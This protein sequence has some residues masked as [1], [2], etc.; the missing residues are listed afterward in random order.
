[1]ANAG[2][3]C[4]SCG[5][6]Y[7]PEVLFCPLDGTPLSSSRTLTASPN[8]IDPY[9]F[10]ELPGQ[11]Q[12]NALVGIGSMGRV[13]RAFQSGVE[14]DV[15]VKI[16]HR[17]LTGN[18][19]LVAR[20]H[21]E[22]KIASRL[23]HPNVVQVLMTGTLPPAID[24]RTGGEV[25]LVMEY[26]D[27]I[28]LLSALAAQGEGGALPLARTLHIILQLCEAVG[29]AHVNNIIHRDLKPENIM[30]VRRGED[31]DFVKVLDFGIARLDSAIE[32]S[33][34]QAG[35][36]FGT[37]KYISPE[38]AEGK[39]VG[40]QADCYAIATIL[41]QCLAGKTPFQG[42][43]P[44]ALLVQQIHG[45][46]ADLRTIPRAAYVPEPIARVVMGNLSK[47][48]EDRSE[49]ARAFGRELSL[50][51]RDAGLHL[52]TMHGGAPRGD[53]RLSSKQ[54]TRQ[55]EFSAE[56]KAKIA[57]IGSQ[58]GAG[59]N[60]AAHADLSGLEGR[61]RPITTYEEGPG[62]GRLPAPPAP[63][64]PSSE[65]PDD[66]AGE[67]ES[68][69]VRP[70]RAGSGRPLGGSPRPGHTEIGARPARQ[71]APSPTQV[72]EAAH[73]PGH[74]Q[75]SPED[76]T[77]TGSLE[78]QTSTSPAALRVQRL[79]EQGILESPGPTI[80]GSP[81]G[82]NDLPRAVATPAG[83]VEETHVEGPI[84]SGGV[85][86]SASTSSGAKAEP[87]R[88]VPAPHPS[89]PR[90]S[91]PG[92]MTN[93]AS[94][95]MANGASRSVH[96]GAEEAPRAAEVPAAPA[97]A[98]SGGKPGKRPPPLPGDT[99]T[100]AKVTEPT[101][102]EPVVKK[103]KYTSLGDPIDGDIPP[104]RPVTWRTFAL[105]ASLLVIVPAGAL[106]VSHAFGKRGADARSFDATLEAAQEA[107]DKRAWDAPP[108]NNVKELTDKLLAESPGDHRVLSLRSKAAEGVLVDGMRARS[109]GAGTT[110]AL[111]LFRLAL[112]LDPSLDTAR[113]FV[114]E[115][116]QQQ[117]GA[118]S[119][120]ASS[121]P[122]GT[123]RPA[124]SSTS[125]AQT[126]AQPGT[127]ASASGA[128]SAAPSGSA[129]GKARPGTPQTVAPQKEDGGL[130][131]PIPTLEPPPPPPPPAGS[132][133]DGPF[134]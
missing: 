6:Q 41:Y 128:P 36:I 7:G 129:K 116:E 107:L 57:S 84:S 47:D 61:K 77:I 13:Y 54:R 91:S 88:V 134:I 68:Q 26:L 44:M 117:A 34:T 124:T 95:S 64:P 15:A 49:N 114:R 133:K 85:R 58:N 119:S 71:Q 66:D 108:G 86:A 53:L 69:S 5:G 9:L 12:L 60:G 80:P 16:L 98:G 87:R 31:P 100:V 111:R 59:Q 115:L 62:D 14:R 79:R 94:K 4:A 56:L 75:L 46:P 109:S 40:P 92:V 22:A 89:S 45:T 83:L 82:S 121:V 131:L 103:P 55:H 72:G 78:S 20:F 8:E 127:S 18:Q 51:A 2:K 48:P 25:Y 93:G 104:P 67:A 81:I 28:S 52:D 90:A 130:E 65:A 99:P 10:L 35:L 24:M 76:V 101:L 32:G 105:I 102:L 19:E 1:M 3:S 37:A 70:A 97:K 132:S 50:A 42:D 125:S 123:D 33:T 63:P 11:I 96:D 118:A 21:R 73:A 112:E 110:E 120:T 43:S 122:L 126:S 30:L 29:E 74:T 106:L 39:H 17:E 23:V 38:G 113:D 27:G